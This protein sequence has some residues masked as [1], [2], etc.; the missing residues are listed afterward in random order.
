MNRMFR[1]VRWMDGTR[2]LYVFGIPLFT[3]SVRKTRRV[4]ACSPE[5][6]ARRL[7]VNVGERCTF[8]VHPR[9]D[10]YPDFGSE[11]Y[12]VS[13][14][15]DTMISFGVTFLTHDGSVHTSRIVT[16]DTGLRGKL[17]KI[18][19][20]RGC[21]IGCKATI[22]PGVE[23]GD[24]SVVGACSVVTKSIPSGQVWAGNPARFVC[25]TAELAEKQKAIGLDD[26]QKKLFDT[27]NEKRKRED[28]TC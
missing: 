16:G 19:V 23:I 7:G 1:K 2:T 28:A 17:G 13:I 10:D 14:G 25:T 4:E 11:P 20:G 18:S 12:F 22:F 15:D 24:C 3:Y 21:F 8:I 5:E 27:C 9:R 6:Y 26:S